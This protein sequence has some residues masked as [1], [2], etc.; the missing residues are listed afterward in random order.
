MQLAQALDLRTRLGRAVRFRMSGGSDD[1][2]S[3]DL[4]LKVVTPSGELYGVF[5]VPCGEKV[6]Q[7]IK[8]LDVDR[9]DT[10]TECVVLLNGDCLLHP[11]DVLQDCGVLSGATLT[12][13]RERQSQLHLH[14]SILLV[15]LFLYLPSILPQESVLLFILTNGKCYGHILRDSAS[16]CDS[17]HKL[18]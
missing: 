15:R 14:L 4:D 6:E 16:W 5:V 9:E 13:L 10:P 7:F 18:V 8:R 1:Y 11:N 2:F 12:L 17:I 3:A